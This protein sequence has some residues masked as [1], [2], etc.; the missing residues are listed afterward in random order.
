[1][2]HYFD[3]HGNIYRVEDER[4]LE[5]ID[6]IEVRNE[7]GERFMLAAELA[8][9]FRL[10][11]DERAT[12]V[13]D[14]TARIRELIKALGGG[15]PNIDPVNIG[16]VLGTRISPEATAALGGGCPNIDPAN[17]LSVLGTLSQLSATRPMAGLE[18]L[19]GCPNIDP[20]N[21][22]TVLGTLVQLQRQP[23]L[24][25]RLLGGGCPAIDPHQIGN[26]LGT[27]NLLQNLRG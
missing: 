3:D 9:E 11:P 13:T 24:L 17:I 15:C 7:A 1:M 26:L 4:K 18:R 22:G 2:P 25:E 5:K 10:T 6:H 27:L 12:V 19:A 16:S 8:D 14:L 20:A 23:A 21:I